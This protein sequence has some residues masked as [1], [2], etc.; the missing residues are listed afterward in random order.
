MSSTTLP[1]VS[2]HPMHAPDVDQL[3]DRLA[4]AFELANAEQD[5]AER[6]QL[7]LEVFDLRA[8]LRAAVDAAKI[9]GAL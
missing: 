9:G 4:E 2:T 8:Q 6:V 1:I 7:I 5:S 3:R